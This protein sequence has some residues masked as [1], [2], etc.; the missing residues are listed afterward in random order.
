M[1]PTDKVSPYTWPIVKKSQ[2]AQD[3]TNPIRNIID[4]LKV[5]PNPTK[6]VISLGLGRVYIVGLW[7]MH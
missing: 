4:R 5:A 2:T 1:T 3:T 6:S 7:S